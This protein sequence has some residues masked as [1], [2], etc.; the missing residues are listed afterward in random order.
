MPRLCLLALFCTVLL[1]PAVQA[2]RY[3]SEKGPLQ[4]DQLAGG[5]EHP[6]ALAFLPDGQGMLI[7]ERPGRLRLF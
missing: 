7:T 2:A 5:L 3:P 6:W 1:T 4:V